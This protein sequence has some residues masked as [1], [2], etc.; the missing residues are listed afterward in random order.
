MIKWVETLETPAEIPIGKLLFSERLASS[1]NRCMPYLDV[2]EPSESPDAAFIVM[3]YLLSTE[4]VPF[5]TIGEAVE[6][7]RQIFEGLEFMHENN[8]RHGDCKYDNI[9]ADAVHL[10]KTPP[11]PFNSGQ[12]LDFSGLPSV[13]FS[14]TRKPVKYYLIDFDL[15]KE[16]PS[17]TPRLERVPWGG[18]RSVPEHKLGVPCDP[19]PVDVY[20]LANCI[21]ENFL[22]GV[23]LIS[24][25]KGFEFVRE[26]ISDMT[27]P[28]PSKRPT[29]KEAAFRLNAVIAG[30]GDRKLR[31]P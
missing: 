21:R 17:G 6:F 5:E 2:I 7:F 27:N 28:D 15:A 4:D 18:D 30:L 1:R 24:A 16:Y 10:Y 12:T 3:P 25:K 9:M 13:I 26:L 31:S 29:M 8:I 14:R 19:F 20:C 23:D 22:D 11:H